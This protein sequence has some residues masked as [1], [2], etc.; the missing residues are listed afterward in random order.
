MSFVKVCQL[1]DLDIGGVRAA[2]VD[3]VT[4]ALARTGEREVYAIN[5]TCSHAN[6]SLSEGEVI[7]CLVECWLHGSEF[8]VRTGEPKQLPA[9]VPVETYAIQLDGDDVLIDVEA[10]SSFLK[11][12]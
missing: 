8:D 7:G 6:V 2:E 10:E 1:D 11:E 12:N 3:G 5:D 4:V 9:T